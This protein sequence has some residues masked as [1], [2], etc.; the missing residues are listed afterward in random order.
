MHDDSAPAAG[1]A[2]AAVGFDMPLDEVA[3]ASGYVPGI[4]V[5]CTAL[6]CF[7]CPESCLGIF[8]FCPSWAAGGLYYTT[9]A[10]FAR[11]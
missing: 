4:L 9:S 6:D 7:Q 5:V 2:G 3:A 1:G 10:W 8:V 11:Y